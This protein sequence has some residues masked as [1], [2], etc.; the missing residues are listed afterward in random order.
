[1]NDIAFDQELDCKGMNCP[2][3]ILKTKKQMDAM[4]SG[5]VLKMVSTDPGSI[6]DMQAFTRRTGHELLESISEDGNYIF[7]VRKI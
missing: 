3:P 2:L 7:L 4:Q 1:M 6:N 5:Q